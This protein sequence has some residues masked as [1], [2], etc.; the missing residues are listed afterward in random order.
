MQIKEKIVDDIAVLTLNGDLIGDPETTKLREKVKSLITDEIKKIVIDL[1]GVS[2][3]NSAG[4]G[5][6]ISV[7]TT[8]RNAG[9]D[10]KLARV[11]KRI[12]S[13]FVITQLVKVFDTYETQERAIASFKKK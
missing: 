4:L 10:L 13:I 12:K 8:V 2:Y 3:I 9:G 7:L 6:L 1:S 5:S 11:G